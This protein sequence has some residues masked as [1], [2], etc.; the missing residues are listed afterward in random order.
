MVSALLCD[1]KTHF[2]LKFII[3]FV[4]SVIQLLVKTFAMLGNPEK[5]ALFLIHNLALKYKDGFIQLLHTKS[6]SLV[7]SHRILFPPLSFT[8]AVPA[9]GT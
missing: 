1:S 3:F 9:P 5:C 7:E 6:F 4:L 2:I 8:P